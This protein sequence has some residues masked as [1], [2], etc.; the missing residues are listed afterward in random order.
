[1]HDIKAGSLGSRKVYGISLNE[2][3]EILNLPLNET[4][5]VLE[6]SRAS[7]STVANTSGREPS[8]SDIGVGGNDS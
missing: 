7:V 2:G 5:S 1:M 8:S 3:S 6:E 4:F